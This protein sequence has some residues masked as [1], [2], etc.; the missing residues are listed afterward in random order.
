MRTHLRK[1][2]WARRQAKQL[3]WKEELLL[4]LEEMELEPSK[5]LL[6]FQLRLKTPQ[7]R[8]EEQP[9]LRAAWIASKFKVRIPLSVLK[10]RKSS[11]YVSEE[12]VMKRQRI[13]NKVK[14]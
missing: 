8:R 13:A 5:R 2:L 7:H 6:L 14:K 12:R 4:M 10:S 1:A 3:M 9:D 11:E